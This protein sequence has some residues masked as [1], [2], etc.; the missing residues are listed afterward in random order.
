MEGVFLSSRKRVILFSI[1]I[2]IAIAFQPL[3]VVSSK[4]LVGT[5]TSITNTVPIVDGVLNND[6]WSDTTAQEITLYKLTDQA[7]EL[8]ISVKS[9]FGMYGTDEVLYFGILIED[10]TTGFIDMLDIIFRVG[11]AE[12]VNTSASISA[13]YGGHDWKTIRVSDNQSV[14]GFVGEDG[15]LYADVD[16]GGTNDIYGRSHFYSDSHYTVELRIPF[17]TSDVSTANDPLLVAGESYELFFSYANYT[18]ANLYSQVRVLDAEYDY[19]MLTIEEESTTTSDATLIS[20]PI[21][22]FLSCYII[23]IFYHRKK[24]S[25][26]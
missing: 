22:S 7:L 4:T 26:T 21:L 17:D 18:D 24:R 12:I 16:Y 2:S 11:P 20:F 10:N 15:L 5:I 3:T 19:I 13:L 14:D 23:A 8:D 9:K 1:V 25:K 6:E